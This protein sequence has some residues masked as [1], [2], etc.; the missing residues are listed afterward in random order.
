MWRGARWSWSEG[1]VGALY[2]AAA[3]I[4]PR[5]RMALGLPFG[6]AVWLGAHVIAVPARPGRV[7]RAPAPGQGGRGIRSAP[8]IWLGHRDRSAPRASLARDARDALQPEDLHVDA[9]RVVSDWRGA[10]R[11]EGRSVQKRFPQAVHRD[12]AERIGAVTDESSIEPAA[13]GDVETVAPDQEVGAR[14][15]GGGTH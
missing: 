4:V 6:A 1:C 15:V 3:E 10:R 9:G 5:V 12:A 8:R 2:G 7:S 13:P 11:G 14:A